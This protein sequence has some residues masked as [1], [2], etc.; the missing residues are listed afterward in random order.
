MFHITPTYQMASCVN[1]QYTME[2]IHESKVIGRG[3]ASTKK[4]AEQ[5]AAKESILYFQ[6]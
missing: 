1:G 4:Q 3:M 6:I 2:V 5:L